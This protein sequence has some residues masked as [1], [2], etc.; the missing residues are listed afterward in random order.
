VDL[1]VK[2]DLQGFAENVSFELAGEQS[3]EI[4]AIPG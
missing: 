4:L 1:K 2:A 3:M